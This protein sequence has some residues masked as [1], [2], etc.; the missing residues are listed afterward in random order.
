MS[1]TF[2]R[3]RAEM[4]KEEQEKVKENFEKDVAEFTAAT[5][6]LIKRKVEPMSAESQQK[7]IALLKQYT[8]EMFGLD[9]ARSKSRIGVNVTNIKGKNDK[10][11]LVMSVEMASK[12]R[13]RTMKRGKGR[14]GG[15]KKTQLTTITAVLEQSTADGMNQQVTITKGLAGGVSI[16]GVSIQKTE[17]S[18]TTTSDAK[19]KSSPESAQSGSSTASIDSKQVCKGK[20]NLF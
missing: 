20:E 2:D 18:A 4:E 1:Q 8:T 3:V 10:E 13:V 12:N 9:E 15:G 17:K 5:K 7:V 19:G 6:R 14:G 16:S 11:S